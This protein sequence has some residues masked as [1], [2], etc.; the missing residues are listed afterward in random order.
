MK[1]RGSEKSEQPKRKKRGK[2][3]KRKEEEAQ[4]VSTTYIM[5]TY[6]MNKERK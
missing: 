6:H 1:K 2:K 4:L 5:R 3:Q